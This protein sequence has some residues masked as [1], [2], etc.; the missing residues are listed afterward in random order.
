MQKHKLLT[1]KR[2]HDEEHT[3]VPRNKGA[4]ESNK[5]N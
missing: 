2:A 1:T 5:G 4:F 3:S